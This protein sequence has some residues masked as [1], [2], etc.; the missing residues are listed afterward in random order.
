MQIKEK[1][2]TITFSGLYGTY[3][4]D[5]LFNNDPLMANGYVL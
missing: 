2:I 5:A 4:D 1:R 3:N